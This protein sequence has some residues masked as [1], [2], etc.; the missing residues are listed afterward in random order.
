M[1][2]ADSNLSELFLTFSKDKLLN[3]YWPR[4]QTIVGSLTDDQIW[5]RPNSA[6]N[7]I[8]N[9]L[10]HLNGNVRQWLVASFNKHEDARNRPAEFQERRRIPGKALVERL[11]Q[12]IDA[13]SEVLNRLT[14]GELAATYKIQGYTVSGLAAIYQVVEHF[15]LHYGQIVYIS[16]ALRGQ[17]LGFYPELDKTGRAS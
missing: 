2:T 10:L 13:A 14:P 4:L 16:K 8:G 1:T 6:C 12:T 5:W 15:G 17:D 3:Q 9:L 7:S 11:G